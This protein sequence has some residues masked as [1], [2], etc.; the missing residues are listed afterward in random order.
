MVIPG[1]HSSITT[2]SLLFPSSSPRGECDFGE[3]D[4]SLRGDAVADFLVYSSSLA[5]A[6]S[7]DLDLDLDGEREFAFWL[8]LPAL[9]LLSLE[10][11][12]GLRSTRSLEPE[13]PR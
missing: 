3:R 13:R 2:F 4:F 11:E 8:S 10:T 1:L 9:L 12:R 7:A 6:F 5:S